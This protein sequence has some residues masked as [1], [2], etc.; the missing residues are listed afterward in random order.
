MVHYHRGTFHCD[1]LS[2]VVSGDKRTTSLISVGRINTW[3]EPMKSAL[4]FCELTET[5]WTNSS[6][7][8]WINSCGETHR[9]CSLCF[10]LRS[11]ICSLFKKKTNNFI[12]LFHFD[13][14]RSV[15]T[16]TN[17]KSQYFRNT[18]VTFC[19][20]FLIWCVAFGLSRFLFG[21]AFSAA[22]IKELTASVNLSIADSFT[23]HA[24]RWWIPSLT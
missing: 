24:Q 6:F 23:A 11:C 5:I 21:L 12:S 4:S 2:C 17:D 14:K 19:F 15:M 3:L 1:V 16:E 22:V 18:P 9:E 10:S 13:A 20:L 8:F 7:S